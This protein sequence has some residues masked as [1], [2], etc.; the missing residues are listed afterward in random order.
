MDGCNDATGATG[1]CATGASSSSGE[2]LSENM[3]EPVFFTVTSE[4]G[5]L[6]Y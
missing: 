6:L 5:Q 4:F 2:D 1:S 3:T